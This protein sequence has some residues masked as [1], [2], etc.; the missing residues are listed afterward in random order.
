MLPRDG[1]PLEA[2]PVEDVLVGH[3]TYPEVK[4]EGDRSMYRKAGT[5]RR[6]VGS[7][8]A[9]LADTAKAGLLEPQS[10]AMFSPSPDTAPGVGAGGT[11]VG[12]DATVWSPLPP[13][14]R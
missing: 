10:R 7:G 2:G 14:G 6:R 9:A 13:G 5:T 3:G 4:V 12:V 8:P 11:T 1:C